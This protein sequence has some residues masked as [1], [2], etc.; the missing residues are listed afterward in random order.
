M[1][2]GAARDWLEDPDFR[3]LSRRK[4]AITA[5]L[6]ATQVLLYFGFIALIAFGKPLLAGRVSP[7]AA[8]TVGIPIAVGVI[9]CSWALTGVYVWWANSTYD[10]LVR[11]VRD[12]I[13]S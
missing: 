2:G 12:R 13:G 11:R 5:A 9:L 1:S 7:G 6:T 3:V 10:T 8:T 4:R